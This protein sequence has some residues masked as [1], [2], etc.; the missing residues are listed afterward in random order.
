MKTP[1]LYGRNP[2]Y[3][4]YTIKS[5]SFFQTDTNRRKGVCNPVFCPIPMYFLGPIVRQVGHLN[6]TYLPVSMCNLKR[7]EAHGKEANRSFTGS[8]CP[9]TP[10]EGRNTIFATCGYLHLV[11]RSITCLRVK[12]K[13]SMNAH[14]KKPALTRSTAEHR[15]GLTTVADMKRFEL[16]KRS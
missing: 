7:E 1:D 11:P 10:L 2:E 5:G 9:L 6:V 15:K 16:R 13:K 4:M 12:M 14:R 8:P 3:V